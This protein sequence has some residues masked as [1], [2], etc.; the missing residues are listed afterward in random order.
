MCVVHCLFSKQSE[1]WD[2]QELLQ[3]WQR[4]MPGV[5]DIYQVS[6]EMLSGVALYCDLTKKWKYFPEQG[7]STDV[8]KRFDALFEEREKWTLDEL[9][10]YL[11]RLLTEDVSETDLLLKYTRPITEQVDGKPTKLYVRL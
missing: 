1:P 11:Q 10:P 5:G 7:L 9:R 2:E 4:E 6:L 8:S 3:Q